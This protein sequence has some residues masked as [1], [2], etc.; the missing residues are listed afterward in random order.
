VMLFM[1]YLVPDSKE[2]CKGF[3]MWSLGER[4]ITRDDKE[5][6]RFEYSHSAHR[7]LSLAD[8]FPELSEGF[9]SLKLGPCCRRLPAL[10]YPGLR[11]DVCTI[12]ENA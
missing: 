6:T 4:V 7:I 12:G 10:P 8:S 3:A 9:L 11:Q 5:D 2:A 1:P